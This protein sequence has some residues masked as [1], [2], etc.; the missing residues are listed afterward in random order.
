MLIFELPTTALRAAT[1]L[2]LNV[3]IDLLGLVPGGARMSA[4]A[5]RPLRRQ[6]A[7]L[8]LDAE[9]SSLTV[10]GALGCFEGRLQ[11]ERCVLF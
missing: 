2:G 9:R 4:L 3:L 5:P 7:L 6:G 1:E 10:R 8:W 11:R